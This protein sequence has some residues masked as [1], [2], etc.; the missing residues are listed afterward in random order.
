MDRARERPSLTTSDLDGSRTLRRDVEDSDVNK[1]TNV[2]IDIRCVGVSSQSCFCSMRR[3]AS[4]RMLHVSV[5]DVR[6]NVTGTTCPQRIIFD[7]VR[8]WTDVPFL[9]KDRLVQCIL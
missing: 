4:L 1:T 2:E 9:L 3:S 7:N 6:I 5:P 8:I